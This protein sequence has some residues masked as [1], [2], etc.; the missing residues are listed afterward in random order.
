[1]LR[2]SPVGGRP[3]IAT[4]MTSTTA[5]TYRLE[6]ASE[7]PFDDVNYTGKGT[8]HKGLKQ[9]RAYRGSS[10]RKPEAPS[11]PQTPLLYLAEQLPATVDSGL[12]QLVSKREPDSVT[13]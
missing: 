10:Q 13:D 9:P 8:S 5:P 11:R 7:S 3:G 4:S 12:F 2:P 1:M 6:E